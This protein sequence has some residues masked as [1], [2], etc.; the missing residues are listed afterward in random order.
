M[1]GSRVS[2]A[3]LILTV[4]LIICSRHTIAPDAARVKIY[5]YILG[6]FLAMFSCDHTEIYARIILWSKPIRDRARVGLCL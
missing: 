5:I 2:R 1:Q 3:T 4:Q 6:Q